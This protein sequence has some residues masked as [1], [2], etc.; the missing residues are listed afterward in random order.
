MLFKL[1][2]TTMPLSTVVF[3]EL[4]QLIVSGNCQV[5]PSL[6][7]LPCCESAWRA[8]S[9]FQESSP[10]AYEKKSQNSP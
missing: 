2:L 6:P 5:S 3:I 4:Y 1:I 8:S 9:A 7:F 10:R